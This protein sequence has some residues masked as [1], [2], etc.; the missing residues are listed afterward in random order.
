M[1]TLKIEQNRIRSEDSLLRNGIDHLLKSL[2]GETPWQTCWPYR[3]KAYGDLT[4]FLVLAAR[5]NCPLTGTFLRLCGAMSFNRNNQGTTPLH[6]ALEAN[7]LSMARSIVRDLGGCLYVAD[8][9]GKFPVDLLPWDMRQQL[10]EVRD[11]KF[12][13]LKALIQNK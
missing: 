9:K 8:S 13:T 2:Q 7:H 10:E 12:V 3:D 4:N 5:N 6:A 1:N 11:R